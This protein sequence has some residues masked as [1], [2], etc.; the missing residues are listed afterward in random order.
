[1]SEL[2]SL[3]GNVSTDGAFD[4]KLERT[5][6]LETD[7]VVN[8]QSPGAYSVCYL[9]KSS[10]RRYGT[11]LLA[12]E[13]ESLRSTRLGIML[14]PRVK[15]DLGRLRIWG[16]QTHAVFPENARRSLDEQLRGDEDT[17]KIV[18]RSLR[19]LNN[20]ID[21]GCVRNPIISPDYD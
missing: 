15:D 18:V 21:K 20:H 14:V 9:F 16:E 7:E 10:L 3:L 12:L 8:N 17:K 2:Y 5:S 1:M 19:R 13:A 11:L 6:Y 4:V